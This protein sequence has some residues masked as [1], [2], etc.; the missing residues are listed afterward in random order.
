MNGYVPRVALTP[1]GRLIDAETVQ[2]PPCAG[3]R[4]GSIKP[5]ANWVRYGHRR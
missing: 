5:C 1:S 2:L 3:V 4:R